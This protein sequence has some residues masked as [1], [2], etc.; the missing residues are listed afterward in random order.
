MPPK[1]LVKRFRPVKVKEGAGFTVRRPVGGPHLTDAAS[2]PFLLLDELGPETYAPG[3]FPGAPWHPHR[4][5]DTV[6]YLKSGEGEHR[7]SMGNTGI[8]RAGDCQW[9]TA[10][11]GIIHDEGRNHP[12]GLLHGFQLWVNLPAANKMD[13]PAYQDVPARVIPVVQPAPGVT[14]KVLAGR[15]AGADAVVQT[16]V[17]VVYADVMCASASAE[18]THVESDPTMETII[19]YVYRGAGAVNDHDVAEGDCL[20]FGP[21]GEDVRFRGGGEDG[22]D[23]LLLVGKPIKE[24]I[25]RCG[26]F[27][28][29]TREELTRCFRDYDEG[30][31]ATRKGTVRTF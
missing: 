22:M 24:P 2:D 29:N 7:D 14:V 26:P 11:S 18:W 20:V 3:D 9:M 31:L 19:A 25:A 27:V 6:T 8:L 10:A 12:G 21:E 1:T 16:K 4:G 30:K 23:A 28:M 15:C 5:F 17:P 13:P